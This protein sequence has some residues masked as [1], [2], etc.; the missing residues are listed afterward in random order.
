MK[1]IG[2]ARAM[3]TACQ[4]DPRIAGQLPSTKGKL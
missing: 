4:R 3:D 2:F 1:P